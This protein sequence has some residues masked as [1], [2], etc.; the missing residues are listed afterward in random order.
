MA[1][2]EAKLAAGGELVD[3]APVPKIPRG[4]GF[5]LST[6]Q[7][8]RIGMTA[9]V[10]FAVIALQEPCSNAVGRFVTTFGGAMDGKAETKSTSGG[11]GTPSTAPASTA[12]M[13]SDGTATTVGGPAP[14]PVPGA[15]NEPSATPAAPVVYERLSP[16]MTDSELRAAIERAKRRAAA[17]EAAGSAAVPAPSPAP[18]TSAP[19]ATPA[20]AP[21]GTNPTSNGGH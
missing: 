21:G 16:S 4:K 19:S 15:T 17:A 9:V 3:E 8:M 2:E 20:P 6:P 1:E 14:A 10:L 13:G 12:V 7:M 5:K 18:S 11:A